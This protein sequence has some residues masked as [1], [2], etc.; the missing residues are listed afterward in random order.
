MNYTLF[1]YQ[2]KHI[3]NIKNSWQKFPVVFDFSPMGSGKSISA[4]A[5]AAEFKHT[6]I[7]SMPT[8]IKQNWAQYDLPYIMLT[9][10]TLRGMRDSQL[11]HNLLTREDI[12]KIGAV[13]KATDIWHQMCREGCLLII[14]EIQMIK[15]KNIGHRAIKELFKVLLKYRET[16]RGILMS[17]TPFDCIEQ[18]KYYSELIGGIDFNDKIFIMKSENKKNISGILYFSNIKLPPINLNDAIARELNN[19]P[20]FVDLCYKL[21]RTA[22]KIVI[23]LF[24]TIPINTLYQQLQK[25]KPAVITGKTPDK[26]RNEIIAEFQAPN[27][28]CRILIANA[29]II[30]TG[31]NLD[32]TDGRFPRRCLLSPNYYAMLSKQ[33]ECRFDRITTKSAAEIWLVF[34]ANHEEKKILIKTSDKEE[35]INK[36]SGD[37]PFVI[38]YNTCI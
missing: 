23:A 37:I 19:L 33:L 3:G 38:K 26:E 22:G 34:S 20:I 6:C 28:N 24:H 21:L 10:N 27:N 29:R 12:Y 32:D 1:N 8:V 9:I 16:S 11:S 18:K 5:L 4:C 31:I 2:Q 15:N 35:I 25:Y 7:I 17:G 13:Y 14:D 30:S 36:Y